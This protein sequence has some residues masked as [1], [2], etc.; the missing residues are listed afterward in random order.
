MKGGGFLITVL[1]CIIIIFSCHGTSVQK[2]YDSVSI[3][4]ETLE[5]THIPFSNVYSEVE[6]IPLENGSNCMLSQV[7]K[8]EFTKYGFLVLN[9]GAYPS[10]LLFDHKGNFVRKIGSLGKAKGEYQHNVVD[11]TASYGGDTIVIATFTS[12]LAY[13][14]NGHFLFSKDIDDGAIMNVESVHGGYAYSTEYHG[15]SYALHFVNSEFAH[16]GECDETDNL[17]L[18]GGIIRDPIR[19]DDKNI[20]YYDEYKTHFYRINMNNYEDVKEISL[21]SKNSLTTKSFSKG[22]PYS[23][24]FDCVYD[25]TV[26]KGVIY[27][28]ILMG[29]QPCVFE[30]NTES[31]MM[32]MYVID[33][34]M[35]SYDTTFDNYQYTL[36]SQEEFISM[37]VRKENNILSGLEKCNLAAVKDCVTEHSNYVMVKLKRK[38]ELQ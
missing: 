2:N 15:S 14:V 17:L 12:L 21:H 4:M 1:C 29:D 36:L 37:F 31:D 34:W 8:V 9:N 7:S 35:P 33:G 27:G 10:V 32:K 13:D 28:N 30:L 16:N 20:Y 38:W 3:D 11:V 26:K 6:F 22:D 19:K 5:R 18:N 23:E 25:Y 24:V